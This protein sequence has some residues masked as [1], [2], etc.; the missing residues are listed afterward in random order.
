V[1]IKGG[2]ALNAFFRYNVETKG[3]MRKVRK[4]AIALL[5][6]ILIA[7]CSAPA[8][9][10]T[11]TA[12]AAAPATEAP[13]ASAT[14]APEASP[15]PT[16]G[17]QLE[18]IEWYRWVTPPAF[19]G[20]LETLNVEFLVRN[21][22]DFPIQV[23]DAHIRLLNSAGEVVLRTGDVFLNV[24]EDIG[25]GIILPGET[26]AGDFYALPG[27]G[28]SAVPEWERFELAFDMEEVTTIAYTSDLDVSMGNLVHSDDSSF[29][30]QGSVTNVS[31]QPL[32]LIFTRAIIR[33]SS[34][35]FVGFGIAGV[36]GDFVDGGLVPI[37]PGESFEF[38]MPAYLNP[39]LTEESLQVEIA[40]IGMIDE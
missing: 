25:W 40:A 39:E 9:T 10:A 23:F 5:F 3:R 6:L 27:F 31:D 26:V 24:A 17:L 12:I 33:D 18:I 32:R 13:A 15:S 38:T 20:D 30:A 14:T 22:Y 34:G 19:D 29:G 21:P 35:Q 37:Q 11:N 28:E 16:P 2:K 8:P 1:I 7:A 36:K 4:F